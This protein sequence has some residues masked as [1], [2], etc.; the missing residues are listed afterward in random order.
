MEVLSLHMQTR[1]IFK[2]KLSIPRKGLLI[3]TKEQFELWLSLL[4]FGGL[5]NWVPEIPLTVCGAVAASKVTRTEIFVLEIENW[6]LSEL[7]PSAL[8]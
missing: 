6:Q 8:L 4:C 3:T 1:M 2:R 7:N 5:G